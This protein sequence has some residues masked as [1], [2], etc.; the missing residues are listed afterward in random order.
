MKTRLIDTCPL[1]TL[2]VSLRPFVSEFVQ[3]ADDGPLRAKWK[4]CDSLQHEP[5]A[6]DA[7]RGSHCEPGS[8]SVCLVSESVNTILGPGYTHCA[9]KFTSSEKPIQFQ[10]EQVK[11]STNDASSKLVRVLHILVR[12][13]D[14][15][16]YC[17]WRG[18]ARLHT[19]ISIYC[20]SSITEDPIIRPSNPVQVRTSPKTQN[21][22]LARN[23]DL[24]SSFLC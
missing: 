24:I 13:G 21:N 2:L 15:C 9:G 22:F 7:H 18:H 17:E 10:T 14:T 3:R 11:D 1:A 16:D 12:D 6:P 8:A 23:L 20:N 4:V 5:C 19:K